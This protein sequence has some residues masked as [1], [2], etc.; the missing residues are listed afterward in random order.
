MR[1]QIFHKIITPAFVVVASVNPGDV[2]CP[3]VSTLTVVVEG[4]AVVTT[5]DVEPFEAT[6]A[7]LTLVSDC[8]PYNDKQR[9]YFFHPGCVS[10]V[11]ILTF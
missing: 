3:V 10:N 6:C 4:S 7:I 9:C 2:P 11:N 1:M 8:K 5:V